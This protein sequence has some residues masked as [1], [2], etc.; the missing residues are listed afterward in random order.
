VARVTPGK[1]MPPKHSDS[2]LHFLHRAGQRADRL[3]ARNAGNGL[4]LPQ[5]MILQ[6]VAERSDQSQI[7][8][9]AATGIDRSSI[10][11][12][13]KRLVR[14]GWLQ[15]RRT[16]RDTRAY[17]VRLTQEGK[18]ILSMAIPA[19]RATEEFLLTSYSAAQRRS[20]RQILKSLALETAVHGAGS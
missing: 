2:V 14:Y 13:V 17:A 11:D 20:F 15:R 16:K 19:A 6:V 1:V 10:T 3:F 5:L 12:L 8:I 7:E 18:R 4:T 9:A